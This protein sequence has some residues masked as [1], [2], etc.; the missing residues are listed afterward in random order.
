[1]S[2]Y[3]NTSKITAKIQQCT[4]KSISNFS[5]SSIIQSIF[6]K[7]A[8]KIECIMRENETINLYAK[9]SN[10]QAICP[11]CGHK[12][13]HV[14]SRYYRKLH[15]LSILGERVCIIFESRKFFCKN[16]TC[17]HKTFAEQPGDEIFRYRRRTRRCE[18]AVMRQGL[19]V[20]SNS[21]SKILSH[22]GI[23]ISSSTILRDLHRLRP[24]E[25][26]DVEKIGVDD[27]A[28]RKGVTYG[29]IIIDI[30]NRH[31][32]DLLGNREME[33]FRD[34]MARHE[35]VNLV[36]RDR[37]TDYSA[38]IASTGRPI[39]EVADKFHL[40]K[41]ILDR[42]TKLLGE[43]YSEYRDLV[44]KEEENAE[45]SNIPHEHIEYKNERKTAKK[46]KA[47]SRLIK[48]NEVKQLQQKGF[49]P[50]TIARKLGIARITA[51]KFCMMEKLPSRNSKLRNMYYKFDEYVEKEYAIG[52]SLRVIFRNIGQLGFNGSLTPFYDHYRYLSDSSAGIRRKESK[53]LKLERP[54]DD[55]SALIPIQTISRLV[56]KKIQGKN[57]AE[58]ENTIKQLIN[59]NWFK[60]MYEATQAFYKIITGNDKMALIRWMKQYWKTKLRTLK[61]FIVGIKMDYKAV[62]NTI[63]Q[64]ITNG[65]TEGFVNKLKEVKR[66]MYGRATIKLLK[67][68]LVLEHIFFN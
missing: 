33:S 27:W 57:C 23:P 64:N 42:M 16:I 34:W 62:V 55:R 25:Y 22:L 6:K 44:R 47:D 4:Y 67:N 39:V 46:E 17:Q 9:S 49:K 24:Q 51:T 8:I 15:D 35:S 29:S 37:S 68:K 61:T 63:K 50:T 1:M 28:Q 32:I 66:N 59:L 41:N 20:S 7:S 45:R 60:E 43:H 36:S 48:F 65:I 53:A 30:Q 31:P 13:C 11:Y 10:R 54:K 12:S 3:P 38:A 18:L 52:E 58:K 26:M 40:I 14:H 56:S 5:S 2:E 19:R 21:A